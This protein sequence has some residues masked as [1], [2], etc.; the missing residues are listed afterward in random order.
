LA[1]IDL[2]AT[3]GQNAKRPYPPELK[4]IMLKTAPSIGLLA[5]QVHGA[6]DVDTQQMDVLPPV[7]TGKA[8]ACFQRI[9]RLDDHL[10]LVI[11][12]AS[13]TQL[14]PDGWPSAVENKPPASQEERTERTH[15]KNES[16]D[17]QEIEALI[18]RKF[19]DIIGRRIKHLLPQAIA[20]A[21][22]QCEVRI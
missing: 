13:L 20:E 4:I 10:V 3:P 8:R 6:L 17:T 18:A 22:E 2:A 14:L 12:A 19:Q 16:P 7:L 21:I 1:L 15:P 5:E 11:D 9:M